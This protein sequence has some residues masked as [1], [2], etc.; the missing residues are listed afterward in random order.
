MPE[1]APRSTP[2]PKED[3]TRPALSRTETK[4]MTANVRIG[5]S[6]WNYEHWRGDYYPEDLPQRDWFSHYARH[7]STVEINNTFYHQPDHGTFDDWRGQAPEGFVYS[8]KANRYLTHL[9]HLK[10]A[11]KP[12]RHFLSGVRRLGEHGGPILYQL[13]P[14]WNRHLERLEKFLKILPQDLEHVFEFRNR[15]WL[16]E[17]TY[18]LLGHYGASLCVHDLL[19]RH[20]RRAT[21][22]VVYV[23]FHGSGKKYGDRYPKRSLRSWASWI[24]EIA[25]D[26]DVDAYFNNDKRAHAITDAGRLKSLL[27]EGPRDS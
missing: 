5:T 4:T 15:D 23:R 27:D 6:G 8:V 3:P 18:E 1:T 21:G 17:P 9:K 25:A 12:L 7:F 26:R 20:P 10:D 14:H 24:Q 16:S 22:R 19:R 2:P 13:P 11:E